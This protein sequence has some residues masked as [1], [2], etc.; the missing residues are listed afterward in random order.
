MD[1]VFQDPM[2]SQRELLIE[3][4][5]RTL[6]RIADLEGAEAHPEQVVRL[7]SEASEDFGVLASGPSPGW[8]RELTRL[9]Q[10]KEALLFSDRL[11]KKMRRVTDAVVEILRA[12]FARIWIVRDGDRCESCF[13]SREKKGA[14]ACHDRSRCLHLVSSSGRYTH[15]DGKAHS[16]V[17][18]GCYKIGRVASGDE[19]GFLTNEV[20][21]DPRVH[22]HEWAGELGLVSFAGYR[23]LAEDGK[24]IGVLAL[25][26]QH[27]L[28][29]TDAAILQSIAD[30][31]AQAIQAG[32]ALEALRES[33]ARY[34]K[35]VEGTSHLL[36]EV[37]EQGRFTYVNR[38]VWRVFG[39]T[40]E[41]CLG[42]LAFDFVHPDD[43]ERTERWFRECS[44]GRVEPASLENRQVNQTTGSVSHLLWTSTFHRSEGRVV[45]VGGIAHDITDR[46][47][48]EE[49]R[50]AFELR[51]RE[52]QKLESLGILAGGIA[53]DFNNLLVGILGNADL[54]LLSCPSHSRMRGPLQGIVDAA[55]RAA[56]LTSQML[57]YSGKG[58]FV[59]EVVDLSR[60]VEDMVR[61]LES[62]I[63]KKATLGLALAEPIPAIEADATQVQQIVMNLVVNASEALGA[64]SGRIEISTG[65]V[66]GTRALLDELRPPSELPEG[67]YV[68][69]EVTDTG[70]G[71]DE[72]TKAKI[73]D[74]F[75][76]TKF[77]GRGL[78]LAAVAG[79]VRGHGGA[80]K[81]ESELDKGTTFTILFPALDQHVEPEETSRNEE[82]DWRGD[83]CVLLVDDEQ[84][85][86]DVG[87]E[88]L[89]RLGFAVI[90]ASDGA[91]AIDVFRS[92]QGE[93]A[94]VLLD[95]KM[96]RMD[97]EEAFHKL[98]A[99]HEEA[100]VLLSSGYGEQDVRQRLAGA[101]L[102]GFVPK[103]YRLRRLRS[104]L[105]D[106]L[107]G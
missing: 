21:R 101:G 41:E 98:H 59:V 83:G 58:R 103:P 54:A 68:T 31:T 102:A 32:L 72:E 90:T 22:D 89:E 33:E 76:T 45:R 15:I 95:L 92:R 60:L 42:R 10:L 66:A 38:V 67:P 24:P 94:C 11:A 3:Q 69:R 47:R 82:E 70:C 105:R 40:P 29:S 44:E 30:T 51:M 27:S 25:F 13:H 55:R 97:G 35:L 57:A 39:I 20:T 6:Q 106:V 88:M 99:I 5:R 61:L 63:S 14:H 12:D 49:E 36:T 96:P 91:E 26:S 62:S 2:T 79:I 84:A 9:N 23:L 37:D 53:H 50:L 86:R 16:R 19:P 78:G 28:S 52:T 74:P 93:V 4:L 104:V 87:K 7:L 85:V 81:V 80:I 77:T 18:F 64:R 73:F 34:R 46:K 48:A 71:M 1:S 56:E 107:G 100:P 75:F 43:R 65:A 8:G 17:P